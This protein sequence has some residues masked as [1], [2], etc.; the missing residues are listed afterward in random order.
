MEALKIWLEQKEKIPKPFTY[1]I[2]P[3]QIKSSI[4][5][6]KTVGTYEVIPTVPSAVFPPPLNLSYTFPSSHYMI[7]KKDYEYL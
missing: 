7:E 3:P 1:R 5:A 2:P 6:K 4:I